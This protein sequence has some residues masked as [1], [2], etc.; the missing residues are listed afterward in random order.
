M[1]IIG[2]M[3]VVSKKLSLLFLIMQEEKKE[4]YN[5]I[6]V[7]FTSSFSDTKWHKRDTIKHPKI[8]KISQSCTMVAINTNANSL[9][10]IKINIVGNTVKCKWGVLVKT[11]SDSS[12][13]RLSETGI[14]GFE[15]Y[16]VMYAFMGIEGKLNKNFHHFLPNFCHI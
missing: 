11:Y 4:Q 8:Q 13:F 14:S 16:M 12:D 5:P 7:S 9:G 6:R 10:V 3:E 1:A 2:N 15:I